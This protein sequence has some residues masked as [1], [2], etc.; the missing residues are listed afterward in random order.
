[1]DIG[2]H[3]NKVKRAIDLL[4]AKAVIEKTAR[5]DHPSLVHNEVRINEGYKLRLKNKEITL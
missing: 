2:I 1:M 3:P 4:I 5:G